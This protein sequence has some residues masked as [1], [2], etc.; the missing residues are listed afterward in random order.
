MFLFNLLLKFTL[1]F[2]TE[3]TESIKPLVLSA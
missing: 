1:K 2:V 3:V